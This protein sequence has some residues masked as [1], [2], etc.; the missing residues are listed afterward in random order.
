MYV[1]AII[2]MIGLFIIVIKD[3]QSTFDAQEQIIHYPKERIKN[4]KECTRLDGCRVRK[5]GTIEW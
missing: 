4:V 1:F 2:I 3:S 5:D